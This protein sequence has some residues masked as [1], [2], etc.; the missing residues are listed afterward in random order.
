[1]NAVRQAVHVDA[2]TRTL[3]LATLCEAAEPWVAR[4]NDIGVWPNGPPVECRDWV[5]FHVVRHA[6]YEARVCSPNLGWSA[7]EAQ[8]TAWMR[9]TSHSLSLN[10]GE[11]R[12]ARTGKRV[13]EWVLDPKHWTFVR[14]RAAVGRWTPRFV[15]AGCRTTLIRHAA[16]AL[17]AQGRTIRQTA[18]DLQCSDATVKRALQLAGHRQRKPWTTAELDSIRS[19]LRTRGEL[20]KRKVLRDVAR[21]LDRPVET[22][23]TKARRLCETD[24]NHGAATG[25]P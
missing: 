9:Q 16:P 3:T 25:T 14:D 24:A 22:I 10:L 17:C 21:L 19:A 15:S 12:C 7:F 11:W 5:A 6:A 2:P 20:S 4:A 18:I 23:R 13:A 8:C 1:M